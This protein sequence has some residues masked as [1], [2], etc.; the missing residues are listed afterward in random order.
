MVS[1]KQRLTLLRML[2]RLLFLSRY[3]D[4]I[5]ASTTFRLKSF[6]VAYATLISTKSVTLPYL[7][8]HI[9]HTL[10]Q[11]QLYSKMPWKYNS[12]VLRI[13]CTLLG[14]YKRYSETLALMNYRALLPM[15]F[16]TFVISIVVCPTL[17]Y[18]VSKR[19]SSIWC[20]SKLWH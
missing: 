9:S 11:S 6:S 16:Y 19:T 10:H 14:P 1:I 8:S 12:Q 18:R 5:R 7:S 17:N 4:A 3:R 2:N 20:K 15:P 13:S